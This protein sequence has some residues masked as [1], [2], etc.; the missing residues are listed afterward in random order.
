MNLI[1]GVYNI[2]IDFLSLPVPLRQHAKINEEKLELLARQMLDNG[3]VSFYSEEKQEVKEKKN[4]LFIVIRELVASSINYNYWYGNG[5][6][7]PNGANSTG[8]Y[9]LVDAALADFSGVKDINEVDFENSINYL[10]EL[11]STQRYPLLEERKR[12]LLELTENGKGITFAWYVVLNKDK[13]GEE[14]LEELVKR[15]TGFASDTFLKRA[16]L[17]FIQLNRQLGW[18]EDL[19]NELFVPADYQVPK[20]LEY[21]KV[22]EY[23]NVLS[24]KIQEGKLVEKG[25][26][27]ECQLRAATIMACRKLCKLTGWNVAEV[28]TWLW[29]KRKLPKSKFHLTYTSDY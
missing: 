3:K 13:H 9:E 12:H 21:F 8:M 25:S 16:S 28:D 11:L 24:Y 6:I 10:I 2:S 27:M 22:I 1:K 19:V 23:S 29:T 17:F 18:F 15:F 26:S 5:L 7:R 14:L 4:E 20:I